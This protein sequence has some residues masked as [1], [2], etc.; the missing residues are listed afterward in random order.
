M[1]YCGEHTFGV[2]KG[3][4][5]AWVDIARA[6]LDFFVFRAGAAPCG[7]TLVDLPSLPTEV[8]TLNVSGTGSGCAAGAGPG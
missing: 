4:T 7:P 8:A 2:D 6:Y 3:Y 1:S 5:E